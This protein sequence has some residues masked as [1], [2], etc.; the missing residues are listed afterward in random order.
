[1]LDPLP[2]RLVYFFLIA[3]DD[4]LDS[5][6]LVIVFLRKF[7]TRFNILIERSLEEVVAGI[8]NNN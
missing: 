7:L 3:I 6:S 1:M 2:Y 5:R 8:F 4:K